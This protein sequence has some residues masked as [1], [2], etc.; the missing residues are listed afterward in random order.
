MSFRKL[1]L[2]LFSLSFFSSTGQSLS[3]TIDVTKYS[4]NLEE[5]NTSDKTIKGFTDL[6]ITTPLNNLAEITLELIELTVDSVFCNDV[7]IPDF[8]HNNGRIITPLEEAISINDTIFMRIYYHGEPF[9]ENWGGF[10]FSGDYAFNLGVGFQSMP[11]NLGKTWFPCVDDFEDRADYEYYITVEETK[12][13]VCGGIL[14]EETSNGDETTTF[15]W[16][17][18][19]TIP[20]YLASV[21]IGEYILY[22]DIYEGKE[23]NVPIQIWCRTSEYNNI[24]GSFINLK[25]ILP[26]YES[27]W[28]AYPFSRVGYVS[29]AKGA[30]EHVG[31]IAYPYGCINGNT[32]DEWLYAHELAH[33]WFGNKVTCSTAGDM[34]LNEG[35]A[36]FNEF[37]YREGLYGEESYMEEYR[38]KH[39][40]VL[41]KAH[42]SSGDGDYYALYDLPLTITYG[43]TAY[44]KG[45][46][47]VHT[48]RNYLGDAVF[49]PAIRA[50]LE[51]FA[52]QPASSFDLRDFL[53]EETGV[54]MTDFFDNWVFTTGFPG[55]EIDSVVASNKGNYQV[56]IQ[57]K[58]RG[59]DTF[60]DGNIIEITF[61]DEEWN[62][63]SETIT[64]SGEHDAKTFNVPFIPI[65]TFV[66]FYDK[67]ADAT[68]DIKTV[69]KEPGEI[70]LSNVFLKINT[71]TI[72]DSAFLRITHNWIAPDSVKD[73][74]SDLRLSDYRYWKIDG[75]IPDN[76]SASAQFFHNYNSS[77]DNTLEI[78]DGEEI[79]L[80][81]R[82]NQSNDWEVTDF[83][84]IG[85][86]TIGY[87]VANNLQKGE[88]SLAVHPISGTDISDID[89]KG[90]LS[91]YPNPAKEAFTIE[92][93]NICKGDINIY[94]V[95][96]A[97]VNSYSISNEK[98]KTISNLPAGTYFIELVSDK[99]VIEKQKV[100]VTK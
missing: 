6:R 49:F 44:D 80:V 27:H 89:S 33:M 23:Q 20:T 59:R 72:I 100:V 57:Q 28:G 88:Y 21:A 22:E 75:I 47:V 62:T 46:I 97:L 98:I 63:Y 3:D 71:T 82:A 24:E 94:N 92:T 67:T 85:Q 4:I 73:I 26:F 76:F 9:S 43:K 25:N 36:V 31:N 65:S 18:E 29:T 86:N 52:Y 42:T 56:F 99:R 40:E 16:K 5:I 37:F 90:K 41:Y 79:V 2:F 93:K 39:Q 8:T 1:L 45:S 69:I 7:K 66:D 64:V 87:L 91:I 50:Y 34:W 74:N 32:D 51:E 83:T 48:L 96:G 14:I 54:D 11:H 58:L 12:K 81:Y 35:W 38:D 61:M 15:H 53:T 77:L 84:M 78:N 10:H 55:F 60:S 68:T 17:M 95:T 13:A 30:M 19:E 70:N